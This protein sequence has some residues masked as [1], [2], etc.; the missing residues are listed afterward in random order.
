MDNILQRIDDLLCTPTKDIKK[1][2]ALQLLSHCYTE[3]ATLQ[4][5]V[6]TMHVQLSEAMDYG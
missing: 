5:E 6:E 2:E 3:I 4:D 1:E